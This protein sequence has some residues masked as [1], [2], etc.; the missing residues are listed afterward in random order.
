MWFFPT[1]FKSHIW[2]GKKR[3]EWFSQFWSMNFI[4]V[5]MYSFLKKSLLEA[6]KE[7]ISATVQNNRI[8]K[9]AEAVFL[10]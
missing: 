8:K 7:Y 4:R 6:D 2:G 1:E 9:A 5:H 10:S 3:Y